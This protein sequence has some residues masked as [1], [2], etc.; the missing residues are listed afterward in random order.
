MLQQNHI[1]P[2]RRTYVPA[3]LA[4]PPPKRRRPHPTDMALAVFRGVV[5]MAAGALILAACNVM[6]GP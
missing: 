3:Y 4:F 1:P 6:F 2:P 5:L